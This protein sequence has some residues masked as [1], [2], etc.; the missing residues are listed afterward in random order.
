MHGG[1]S[2]IGTTAIP[3]AARLGASAVFATAGSAEKAAACEKLGAGAA[4]ITR[5]RILSPSC[6]GLTGGRGVDVVLD[7]V[8]GHYFA[9]N[10]DALAPDGRL[11]Q[12]AFLR[13]RRSRQTCSP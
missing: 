3:L 6:K 11:V 2:G 13:A 9:R 8:G 7:M 12:I 5:T 10:L 4:L 1:T